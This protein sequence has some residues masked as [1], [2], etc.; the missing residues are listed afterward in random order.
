MVMSEKMY[1][2]PFKSLMNWVVTEYAMSGEIFGVHQGL[3]GQR[4]EPAHFR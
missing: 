3:Q 1:P 4:Q 2:I